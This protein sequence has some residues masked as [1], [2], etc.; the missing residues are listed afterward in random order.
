MVI[1]ELS[2][3]EL[4]DLDWDLIYRSLLKYTKRKVESLKWPLGNRVLPSGFDA[5]T[6]AQE[7]ITL[8][9]EGKR[10]WNPA[11]HQDLLTFLKK[12]VADSLVSHL[13][14]SSETRKVAPLTEKGEFILEC[15]AIPVP[16]ENSE[17]TERL[18]DA[19]MKA[20]S[21]DEELSTVIECLIDDI[22]APREIAQKMGLTPKEVSRL[23]ER[24][25]A[26]YVKLRDRIRESFEEAVQ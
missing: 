9:L 11:K 17:Y 12:S 24:L 15:Q 3:E 1:P 6:L 7:A 16:P 22:V 18:F 5:E 23:K 26:R 20:T 8:F 25:K 13:I 10:K 2:A 21:T 19:V 4:Q 14:D